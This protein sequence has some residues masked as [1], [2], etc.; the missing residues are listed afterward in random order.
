MPGATN[1]ARVAIEADTKDLVKL[2]RRLQEARSSTKQMADSVARMQS[3]L[4]KAERTMG[5]LGRNMSL[6]LTAP[7]TA[8]GAAIVKFGLEFG[9][10]L[11]TMN[12]LVGVSR[13]EIA[14][15]RKEVLQLAPTVGRG[16]AELANAL[17]A[18][19][20]AGQR[21]AAAMETLT[22][23]S[24][25]SAIGLG[26]TRAIALAA[27]AAVQAYGEA[28]ITSTEAVE[29]LVGTIEQGNLAAE[30]LAP[31]LG[32]VIGL[33]AEMGITF[34]EVGAFIATYTRLGINAEE[35]TT[36]LQG[37]M[38]GLLRVTPAVE[39][40]FADMNMTADGFRRQIED[41][42]LIAAFSDLAA[43]AKANNTD[44]SALVPNVRALAGVLGVFGGEGNTAKEVAEGVAGAVGTLDERLKAL[45]EL[46]PGFAVQQMKSEL[47][48]LAIELS[49]DLLPAFASLIELLRDA[50]DA[51]RSLT[52]ETR[53]TV[54]QVAAF[55]AAIGPL[56]I[57]L[58]SVTASIRVLLGLLPL[59]RTAMLFLGPTG[60]VVAAA[61][62]LGGLAYAMSRTGDE[63][64]ELTDRINALM[65]QMDRAGKSQFELAMFDLGQAYQETSDEIAGMREE[66][67]LLRDLQSGP[68]SER[69]AMRM[70][71]LAKEIEAATAKLEK[72]KN[73]MQELSERRAA[74]VPSPE[75]N[76]IEGADATGPVEAYRQALLEQAAAADQAAAAQKK[77][78]ALTAELRGTIN[79][80]VA[81]QNELNAALAEFAKLS[82][83]GAN[84]SDGVEAALAVYID[85]IRAYIDSLKEAEDA[86][87]EWDAAGALRGLEEA[88]DPSLV[89]VNK[90]VDQMEI[91]KRLLD[92]EV[93][94]GEQ[95]DDM[96]VALANMREEANGAANALGDIAGAVG[97]FSSQLA[98]DLQS[99]AGLFKDG[100][101]EAKQLAI[102]ISALNV[103][104]GVAAVLK[105]LSEGDVYSAIPRAI[106]V[107]GTVAA[108]GVQIANLSGG[109]ADPT[110]ARQESLGTGTVLGD[111]D[112]RS[113][114]IINSLEIT[115]NAT[116]ELVGI[117]R[118]MLRALTNLTDAIAGATTLL[119]R[120][121]VDLD[122]GALPGTEGLLGSLGLPDPVF[123][124]L[125][126]FLG[127]SVDIADTGITIAGGNL[128]ELLGGALIT[129]FQDLAVKKNI[130]DDT[131]IERR[132]VELSDAVQSQFGAVFS[133]LVDTVREAAGVLGF[134][135][136]E[137]QTALD[138]FI[139]YQQ[140]ISFE[141][142][143]AEEQQEALEAFFSTVFDRLAHEVVPFLTDLQQLGEGMGETLVRVATSVQVFDYA[144][145]NI[146][147]LFNYTLEQFGGSLEDFRYRTTISKVA[148]IELTGG[149]DA[150]IEGMN[151]FIDGFA[152]DEQK[153]Q[154]TLNALTMRFDELGIALPTTR[155]GLWDLMQSLDASTEAG[156]QGIATLL[157]S[158]PLLEAYY[159]AMEAGAATV[160]NFID[161]PGG[162]LESLTQQFRAAMEA[163]KQ[164][165]A[166]QQEYE[167][168]VRKFSRNLQ[169][170][171]A[172]LTRSVLQQS[173]SLFGDAAQDAA[174][175]I[176]GGLTEV[177]EVSNS[178]FG[179][180]QRALTNLK[181]FADGLLLDES[182]TP[183]NPTQRLNEA[184]AQF[185]ETLRRALEGDVDAAADLPQISSEFLDIARFMFASTGEYTAIFNR[186]QEALRGIEM[187]PG[188]EEF[189]QEIVV[190][191][192]LTSANTSEMTRQQN[193]MIAQL[194]RLIAAMDL[195]NTL[196]ELAFTL[197]Q[198]PVAIAN[199]LGV[200][201]K[202]LATA[203]GIDLDSVSTETVMGIINMADRL[204]ADIFNLGDA[205]GV[206][207]QAMADQFGVDISNLDPTS[208]FDREIDSLNSI[209]SESVEQ[210]NLLRIIAGE[211]PL[212]DT[213]IP[214]ERD[215]VGAVDDFGPGTKPRDPN[216]QPGGTGG[217]T[218]S[219]SDELLEDTNTLL[220]K[221]VQQQEDMKTE[222]RILSE[223]TA[224]QV[225]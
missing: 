18:I 71:E 170:L 4:K 56:L 89:A 45:I 166:S 69:E 142:M 13:E 115:A 162:Q 203:L 126:D 208:Q 24:K 43:A 216:D 207:I 110:A 183:L 23:A 102:A 74:T 52:P 101:E 221:I 130:F 168:I 174:E 169:R 129:A 195:S 14:Q 224:R 25:A 82:D 96:A 30:S 112:A 215:P 199:E 31:V 79:P 26:D 177:R 206:D 181:G 106:A 104:T 161:L 40:A 164:L 184:E 205:L 29:V 70:A 54:V 160:R 214:T 178:L 38:S 197:G 94:D 222:L 167:L 118:G 65:E 146:G 158:T 2:K 219:P 7:L 103:V 134:S 116:E 131:D 182:V 77:V 17:F 149:L 87:E 135:M 152:S 86:T 128:D 114:S 44:I 32:R 53:S 120:Q 107:A 36:S 172:E 117:N 83:L 20:S 10:T 62:A 223:T 58:G 187:P 136:E 125:N 175:D 156:R 81:A 139:V 111:A 8:A 51:F 60:L 84:V 39:A 159:D 68:R 78:N 193:E 80:V 196:G 165:N 85:A 41:E 137:I 93:I 98:G 140:D 1:L 155:D 185:E 201:L 11:A 5:K 50:V 55:A 186:V 109:A 192:G 144:F 75:S 188:I 212:I 225:S 191:T 209:L 48:A 113:E 16:P 95:F 210:T 180:W 88:I 99:F 42:G 143:N 218:A 150:F 34:D 12:T 132:T 9:S 59:L 204:G 133:A 28:N 97:Q 63:A 15:F 145:E 220:T 122:F 3:Q 163:A 64:D 154:M 213:V 100:S 57:V 119:A 124:L 189:T 108:L 121:A 123:G 176:V 173:L 141:D 138:N 49:A 67:E 190:N 72:Y 21:G 33:A 171:G 200:P 198:S 211:Q 127:G 153:F 91:L 66:M 148:L 194:D 37:V 202:D 157:E 47:Q 22:A 76:L 73:L 90:F 35:A 61:S 151:G 92:D 46:D 179:E 27:G 105:Q 6:G 147:F 217:P 19:T